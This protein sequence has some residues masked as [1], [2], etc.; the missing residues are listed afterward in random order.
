MDSPNEKQ[1][2][3]LRDSLALDRTRLAN[4]RTLLSFF[5]T[6]LTLVVTAL[7][8]FELKEKDWYL[9]L[10]KVALVVGVIIIIIGFI[11]FFIIKRRIDQ[12]YKSTD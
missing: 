10:G 1:E 5:R 8:I 7:A 2:L 4:Q 9:F 6:G 12:S 11:N 3:I